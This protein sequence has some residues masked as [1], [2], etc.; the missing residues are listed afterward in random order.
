MKQNLGVGAWMSV[1]LISSSISIAAADILHVSNG[2]DSGP[3]SF[4]QALS[5]ADANPSITEIRFDRG[6]ALNL[7]S[8]LSYHG[9]QPLS[10]DGGQAV[11]DG[12]GIERS[13]ILNIDT[14]ASIVLKNINFRNSHANGVVVTVPTGAVG[15]VSVTLDKV[16]IQQSALYGLHIDDNF[17]EKDEGDA[18][19]A[20]GILLTINDSVF[21]DNGVG[22]LDYDG[23]RV[24]ERGTGDIVA[25]VSGSRIDRNG[26]DGL[27]LDEGGAGNVILTMVNSQL[28][29]NGFFNQADL[30][31]GLDIDEGGAGD[32]HVTLIGVHANGNYEQ[33]IDLDEYESGTIELAFFDVQANDN[34][35]EGIKV[36]E[37]S[38]GDILT[39][40]NRVQVKSGGQEG[41]QIA[42]QGVGQ[43][44][45]ALLDVE[46]PDAGYRVERKEDDGLGKM[47]LAWLKR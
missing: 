38:D 22:E 21:V 1:F 30:D 45:S 46:S 19:S 12:G 40:F 14:A 16:S 2:N 3:G 28:D 27:E 8:S 20:A 15:N 42:Q 5:E 47:L 31:D 26:G 4:R 18:G 37:D 10:I 25:H 24:D 35:S 33:G 13:N 11:I 17:H 29:R 7:R 32:V 39:H 6:Y 34:A 9:S 41:I 43:V 44:Y 23:I 36:D